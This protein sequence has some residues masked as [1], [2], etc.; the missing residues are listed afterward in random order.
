MDH[1]AT[2]RRLRLDCPHRTPV[3]AG[4]CLARTGEPLRPSLEAGCSCPFRVDASVFM[5]Q[6]QTLAQDD[7]QKRRHR[8]RVRSLPALRRSRTVPGRVPARAEP[9]RRVTATVH[10]A[11]GARARWSGHA[12]LPEIRCCLRRERRRPLRHRHRPVGVAHGGR[13][14][15]RVLRW[16]RSS[17][18]CYECWS[19]WAHD[20]RRFSREGSTYP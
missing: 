17:A 13:G 9:G 6:L 14:R 10:A 5:T 2:P 19:A 8:P 3:I 16:V 11:A 4:R 20:V 7:K 12:W 15:T 1:A 18:C